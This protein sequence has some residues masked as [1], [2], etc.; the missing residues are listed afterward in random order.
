VSLFSPALRARVT[1]RAGSRC[2]YCHL[3][4]RGQVAT[5]P[6]DHVIPKSAGGSNEDSNLALCCPHCN[7]QK[8]KTAEATDPVS[9]LI[10]PYFNPRRD[11][12]E[13]HFRWSRES[14]GVL[15]GLTPTGRAT[16]EG[17]H[18]NDSKMVELRLLLG[19]LGLF[20]EVVAAT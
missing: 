18:L 13:E 5:F 16:V 17:L 3:P 15:V 4:T 2:E 7:A 10:A 12:W 11:H 6:I 9:G 19:E 20:P 1:E 8:W 14:V